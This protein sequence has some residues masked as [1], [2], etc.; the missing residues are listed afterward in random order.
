MT[1]ACLKVHVE[2]CNVLFQGVQDGYG[3]WNERF[4]VGVFPGQWDFIPPA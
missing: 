1:S 3:R 2:E 4:F